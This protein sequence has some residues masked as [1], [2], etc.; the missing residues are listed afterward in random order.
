MQ[1]G[2]ECLPRRDL[3]RIAHRLA[4]GGEQNGVAATEGI[5]WTHTVE[6]TGNPLHAL[7]LTF[8]LF[9][10]RRFQP[11]PKDLKLVGVLRHLRLRIAPL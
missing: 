4:F 1:F 5:Q 6:Q 10:L 3:C 2:G 11:Q 7:L 8:E 9:A